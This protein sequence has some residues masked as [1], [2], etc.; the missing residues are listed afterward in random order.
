MS[1]QFMNGV[2]VTKQAVYYQMHKLLAHQ[3]SEIALAESIPE[4]GWLFKWPFQIEHYS[5]TGLVL[6]FQ[7]LCNGLRTVY[8]NLDCQ[9]RRDFLRDRPHANPGT[10]LCFCYSL[11]VQERMIR[12]RHQGFSKNTMM[13]CNDMALLDSWLIKHEGLRNFLLVS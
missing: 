6:I 1:L 11:Q 8:P 3:T 2:I 7:A 4:F 9:Y 13:M 5:I 10:L 12:Q